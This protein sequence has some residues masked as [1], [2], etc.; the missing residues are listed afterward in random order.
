MKTQTAQHTPGPWHEGAGNGTGFIWGPEG[1]RRTG[2]SL[3]PIAQVNGSADED[4]ANAAL[5]AAA[6]DMFAI[7]QRTAAISNPNVPWTKAE[8]K[9]SWEALGV[10]A[11]ELLKTMGLR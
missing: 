11:R 5:V 7:V 9:R 6:P 8:T 1:T 3:S 4:H 2:S 10:E